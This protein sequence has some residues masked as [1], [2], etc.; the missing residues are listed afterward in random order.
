MFNYGDNNNIPKLGRFDS[1]LTNLG[2][3]T[4][5]S[6][7]QLSALTSNGTSFYAVWNRQEINGLVHVVGSRVSTAGAIL[8]GTRF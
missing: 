6:D 2:P 4:L 7:V 5:P 8:D 1:S 3:A